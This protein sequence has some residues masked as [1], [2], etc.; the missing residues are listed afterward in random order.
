MRRKEHGIVE[1]LALLSVKQGVHISELFDALVAA[2]KNGEATCQNLAIR[3]R[4]SIKQE[5]IFS[6]TKG[7][8]VV[9]Q[10]RLDEEFLSR[11]DIRFEN[12]MQTDKIRRRID[13]QRTEALFTA[14]QDLRIGMKQVNLEA[15][16]LKTSVPSTVF[17]KYGNSATVTNALIGDRTGSVKLC[18]WNEQ[19]S[20][21][22]IGNT[23]QIKNAKVLTYKGERQLHLGKSGTV[24]V[25]SPTK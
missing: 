23:I 1:H 13:R 12:W 2:R 6:V 11:T 4:G 16:V 24:N 10:F 15:E 20:F 18:L 22:R 19:A 7:I 14:V 8:L 21:L 5:A 3:Y 25:L 9:G 17:T